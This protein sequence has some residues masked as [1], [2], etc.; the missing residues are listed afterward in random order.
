M[1]NRRAWGFVVDISA[2]SSANTPTP[3][4]LTAAVR[5]R[6]IREGGAEF[7]FAWVRVPTYKPNC[8]TSVAAPIREG[9]PIFGISLPTFG[10]FAIATF[11]TWEVG[12]LSH[13]R[14]EGIGQE[15]FTSDVDLDPWSWA[16]LPSLGASGF[17]TK[18]LPRASRVCA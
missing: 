13:W 9:T 18:R 2:N 7:S 1:R 6:Y 3:Y 10:D 12:T 17:Y 5:V 14:T 15:S 11:D 8:L 16:T 4:L